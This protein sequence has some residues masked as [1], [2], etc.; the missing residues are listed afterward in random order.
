MPVY[1]GTQLAGSSK[2]HYLMLTNPVGGSTRAGYRVRK[3]PLYRAR[4]LIDI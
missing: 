2:D 3:Q 1:R 4:G